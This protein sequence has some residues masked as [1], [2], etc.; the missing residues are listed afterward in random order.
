MECRHCYKETTLTEY[1][2]CVGDDQVKEDEMGRA[3]STNGEK[4]NICRTLVGKPEG[5]RLLGIPRRRWVDN[6]RINVREDWVVI[7]WIYL[8]QDASQWRYIV[9]TVMNLRVP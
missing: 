9:N 1:H 6:I 7:N 4:T 8:A 5:N 3:C 2:E